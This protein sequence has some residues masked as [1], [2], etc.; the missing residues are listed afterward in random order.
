MS[1]IQEYTNALIAKGY[2]ADKAKEL[3]SAAFR[4]EL[5][6]FVYNPKHRCK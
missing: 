3:A 2:S 1:V 6:R 4:H 5:A